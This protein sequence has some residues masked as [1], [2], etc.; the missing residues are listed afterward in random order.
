MRTA[1]ERTGGSCRRRTRESTNFDFAAAV[2]G[3]DSYG[4]GGAQITR[5]RLGALTSGATGFKTPSNVNSLG[6]QA[7]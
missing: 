5:P 1:R 6:N 3:D 4:A 7:F 2:G